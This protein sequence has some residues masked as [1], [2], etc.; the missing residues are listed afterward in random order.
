MIT[1]ILNEGSVKELWRMLKSCRHI[2]ITC[3]VK[4]DGDAIGS[5]LGLYHVLSALGKDV[6]VVTPDMPARHLLFLPGA[7]DIVVANRYE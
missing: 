6:R 1:R 5:S 7:K 4:P 2:V 3:H